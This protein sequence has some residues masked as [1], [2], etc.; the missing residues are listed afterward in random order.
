MFKEGYAR[1]YLT[2]L[3]KRWSE[4]HTGGRLR[5]YYFDLLLPIIII[6]DLLFPIIIITAL[7]LQLTKTKDVVV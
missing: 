7:L 6:T 5:F 3:R 2:M 4:R 1:R